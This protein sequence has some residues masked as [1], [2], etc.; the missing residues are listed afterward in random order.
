MRATGEEYSHLPFFPLIWS[1]KACATSRAVVLAP[2][3]LVA[4]VQY[5]F[6]IGRRWQSE[7]VCE[8]E[9]DNALVVFKKYLAWIEQFPS[10]SS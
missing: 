6:A 5:L 2:K 7:K 4:I 8:L 10:K 1:L 3:V 9:F